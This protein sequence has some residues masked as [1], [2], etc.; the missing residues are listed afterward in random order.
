MP[1]AGPKNG[2]DGMNLVIDE[3]D[4]ANTMFAPGGS[5]ASGTWD[6]SKDT[7]AGTIMPVNTMALLPVDGGQAGKG[8]HV[9]GT[10]LVGWGAALAAILNGTTSSFDASAFDGVAFY[11][12]GTSDVFE[13]KDKLFVSA[14]MYELLPGTGSCCK[15]PPPGM[16]NGIE[17]YATHF[18]VVDLTADWKEVKIE[19]KDFGKRTWGLGSSTDFNPNRIRDIVFGFN[20]D[21][22]ATGGTPAA[23]ASFDVYID[24]L[25]FLK[26]GE[27][28]NVGGGMGGSN[29]GGASA[30]G[31]NGG[32]AGTSAGGGGNG[33]MG[34]Q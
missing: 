6:F 34:G 12:K 27:M 24:G 29:A 31:G 25:R 30:G 7:S 26:K 32:M 18:T 20:H 14:R 28:G 8:L 10:G 5:T 33:G 23:G 15:D 13:G 21:G 16:P 2:G 3:L 1:A 19:W 17:C 4:D 11:T 22:A 9:T